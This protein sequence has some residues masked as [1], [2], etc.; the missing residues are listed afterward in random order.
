MTRVLVV[1]DEDEIRAI[2]SDFLTGRGFEVEAAA[3]GSTALDLMRSV[4]PTVVLLDVSMPGMSGLDLLPRLKE[5]APSVP[6]IMLTAHQDVQ[7]VV[8]AMRHGAFDYLAKPAHPDE[9]AIAVTRAVEH[10]GLLAEV[11]ALRT[12]LSDGAGLRELMGPSQAVAGLVRQVDQVARSKFTVLVQGETGAGKE[13]VARAIHRQSGNR[14]GPFVPV[15]CGAIPDTL[16]ES[17]LFGHEKGAFTG[18]DQKKPGQFLL[19]HGGTLF[20]DEVANLPPTAQAKLLRVLQDRQVRPLGGA[21]PVPVDVRVIAAANLPLAA[22][23]T[24]GRFRQDLFYRLAEFAIHVPPLR[25]RREDILPLARRFLAET[26]MELS[27]AVRGFSEAAAACLSEH[28][29]PGNVREL[30]NVVRRAVLVSG[31]VVE[32]GALFPARAEAATAPNGDGA[33]MRGLSLR[34]VAEQATALAE[35]QAIRTAL[36]QAGGNKSEA[37]RLLRTDFKTLHMKMRL[38]GILAREYLHR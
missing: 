31:E 14:Q 12:A 13:L 16:M 22:E 1:D 7:T 6:V 33:W 9:I 35:G 28:H 25:E 8:Q 18:A 11:Q 17:E 4:S 32:A 20:L 2:L 23:V 3:D 24:K 26:G 38:R 10:L 36:E 19:A 5:I 21:R 27:R 29:W 34:Q 15:D 30:R 37:A